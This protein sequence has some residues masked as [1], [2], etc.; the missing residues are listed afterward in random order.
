MDAAPPTAP[1]PS[2]LASPA[3]PRAAQLAA[4][5]LLGG[6]IALLGAHAWGYMGWG[7]RPTELLPAR[8]H[9]IDL[10]RADRAELLQLRG[11]GP[12][13]AERIEEYRKERGGFRSVEELGNVRGVGPA[14]LA[15]LRPYVYVETAEDDPETE[16]GTAPARQAGSAR[17]G[18]AGTKK[19]GALSEPIDIN[20]ATAAELCRL[21][22]IGP[23]RS[24]AI[25]DERTKA[26]FKS[27]DDLCRVRGIK[28]KTVDKLRPY[29]TVG[30]ESQRVVAKE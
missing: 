29:V 25:V 26:P 19:A 2:P 1:P 30:G 18:E 17:K 16:T 27:V 4:A 20:T 12:P 7:S 3:W 8:A 21:P 28:A 6:A 24:Q 9:R 23:V 5:L 13:L 22:D 11:V 10:N 14:T 15:R